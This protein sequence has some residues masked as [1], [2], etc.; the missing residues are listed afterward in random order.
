[1][2]N[3]YHNH[4]RRH[5]NGFKGIVVIEVGIER[6]ETL[7]A[8]LS[9]FGGTSLDSVVVVGLHR[10][11]SLKGF[12]EVTTITD[13]LPVPDRLKKFRHLKQETDDGCG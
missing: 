10:H 12:L 5:R 9:A 2:L 7:N 11:I 13:A 1:M 8:G 3:G 6:C 4:L